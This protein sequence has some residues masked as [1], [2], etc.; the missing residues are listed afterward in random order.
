MEGF[1]YEKYKID[2]KLCIRGVRKAVIFFEMMNFPKG[3]APALDAQA[4]GARKPRVKPAI[5]V[6]LKAGP[7][8]SFSSKA[9]LV[10]HLGRVRFALGTHSFL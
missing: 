3:A 10:N 5:P 4:P 2:S 6:D 8:L 7:I 1:F 9:M